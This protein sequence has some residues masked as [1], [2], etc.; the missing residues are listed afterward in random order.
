MHCQERFYEIGKQP[1]VNVGRRLVET[2]EQEPGQFLLR[3]DVQKPADLVFVFVLQ[4]AS[5]ARI[6]SGLFW[7]SFILQ[8][9]GDFPAVEV[10]SDNGV[11]VLDVS[12]RR[13]FVLRSDRHFRFP[14]HKDV[15]LVETQLQTVEFQGVDQV[16]VRC[17]ILVPVAVHHWKMIGEHVFS[18]VGNG[19]DRAS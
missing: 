16:H 7:R 17:G 8:S 10:D 11:V 9:E 12:T 18:D 15:L 19:I 14:L 6:R 1:D 2:V 5:N 13:Q 4:Q 3:Y